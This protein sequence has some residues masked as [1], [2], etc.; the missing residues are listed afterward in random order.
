MSGRA[1]GG[2]PPD[3]RSTCD[4]LRRDAKSF[5]PIARMIFAARLQYWRE[6]T[7]KAEVDEAVA[8]ARGLQLPLP[9]AT[10]V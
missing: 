8:T 3:G 1:K 5:T 4:T 7:T 9:A 6:A 2:H 10:I